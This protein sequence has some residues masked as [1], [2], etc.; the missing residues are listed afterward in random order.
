MKF[1]IAALLALSAAAVKNAELDAHI[2]Y[3]MKTPPTCPPE[4]SAEEQAAGEENPEA[5][6]D[7]IDQDN[8]G[9][10]DAR[11][12]FEALYCAASYGWISE[13]EARMAFKYLASFAGDD[14]LL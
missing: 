5:V 11:E 7:M 6:F 10:I 8:N 12:G 1:Y 14:G 13:D 2:D 9:G 4:P 3:M